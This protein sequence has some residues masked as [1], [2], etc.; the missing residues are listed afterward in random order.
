MHSQEKR[1]RRGPTDQEG[2]DHLG[3]SQ[4]HRVLR[5]EEPLHATGL[6]SRGGTVSISVRSTTY[7]EEEATLGALSPRWLRDGF[8]SEHFSRI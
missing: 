8:R 3:K 5:A 7:R 6:V 2:D 1:D 4:S